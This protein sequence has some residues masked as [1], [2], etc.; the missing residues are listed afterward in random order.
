MTNTVTKNMKIS[1]VIL[2]ESSSISFYRVAQICHSFYIQ[3]FAAVE[4]VLH[5]IYP[6]KIL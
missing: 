1:T 6:A 5:R 3:C 2:T 4:W